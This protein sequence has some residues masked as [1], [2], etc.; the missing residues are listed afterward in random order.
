MEHDQTSS[1]DEDDCPRC[2][3]SGRVGPHEPQ[4]LYC[5]GHGSVT[6]RQ[7]DQYDPEA[8]VLDTCPVCK[9]RGKTG[10]G[11]K[12]RTCRLCRGAKLIPRYRADRYESERYG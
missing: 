4:C 12:K 8:F 11:D 5:K 6:P 3:G 7:R 2:D 1:P 9:G 10:R